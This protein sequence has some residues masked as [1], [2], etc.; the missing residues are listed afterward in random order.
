MLSQGE[1]V[2][3]CHNHIL[4]PSRHAYEPGTRY[5]P[6]GQEIGT[7]AQLHLVCDTY[8]V[9]HCLVVGPNSG[10]GCDNRCLLD[11]VGTSNGRFKG[12]A[13]VPND[14]SLAALSALKA[15]G[16]VGIAVNVT[17]HGTAFYQDIG[18]LMGRLADLDLFLQ[19][20]AEQDQLLALMPLFKGYTGRLIFDHCGRPDTAAGLDRPAFQALLSFGDTGRNTVKL[21]SLAKFARTPYPYPDAQPYVRAL[22]SAFGLDA[23]VW[24]SDWPFLRSGERLDYG[25]LLNLVGTLFPDAADRRKLLWETPKRLFGFGAP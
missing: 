15:Q 1:A 16:I 12:I 23:C 5:S 7:A 10:Y 3:D 22:V 8:G 6:A 20:Q 14:A 25:P 17:F 18:P 11:A 13:V 2:I 24:G 19:V 21:S 9:S 4:D